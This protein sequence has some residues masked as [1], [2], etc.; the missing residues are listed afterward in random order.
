MFKTRFLRDAIVAL[1]VSCL[2]TSLSVPPALAVGNR[3]VIRHPA[4]LQVVVL[5][6]YLDPSR[7]VFH[8]APGTQVYRVDMHPKNAHVRFVQAYQLI[9]VAPGKPR[10]PDARTKG[11][12]YIVH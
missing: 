2:M 4:G 10:P 6:A 11:P 5:P 3:H 1:I 8:L 12:E 7:H 9:F